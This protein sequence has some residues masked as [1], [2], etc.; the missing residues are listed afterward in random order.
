MRWSLCSVAVRPSRLFP[1]CLGHHRPPKGASAVQPSHIFPV[2]LGHHRPPKGA[3][4]VLPF[5]ENTLALNV[6]RIVL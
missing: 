1:V 4:A 2:C 6:S 3:S 5:G